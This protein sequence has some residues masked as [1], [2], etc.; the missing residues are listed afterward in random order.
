MLKFR[1]TGTVPYEMKTMGL[2]PGKIHTLGPQA[3][4]DNLPYLL[5]AKKAG[6]IDDMMGTVDPQQPK[7]VADQ[8]QAIIGIYSDVRPVWEKGCVMF[9]QNN[10][11][12]Y[13]GGRVYSW[14]LGLA[15][16]K[17]GIPASMVSNRVPGFVDDFAAY[18]D[19][20]NVVR[21]PH[22]DTWGQYPVPHDFAIGSPMSGVAAVPYGKRFGVPSILMVFDPPNFVRDLT[23][24]ENAAREGVWAKYKGSLMMADFVLALCPVAADY[25]REWLKGYPRDRVLDLVPGINSL[26]QRAAPEA[27]ERDTI[28]YLGRMVGFKQR[29]TIFKIASR[30]KPTPRVCIMG[31]VAGENNPTVFKDLA[32]DAGVKELVC[33]PSVDDMRKFT[34][35]KRSRFHVT[36]SLFEGFGMT[37]AES[38]A[39][40]TPSVAYPLPSFTAEYGDSID[41]ADAINDEESLCRVAEKLWSDDP[42]WED[43]S[44]QAV[45]AA[46]QFSFESFTQRVH[47]MFPA[48]KLATCAIVYREAEYLKQWLLT[49]MPWSNV[50]VL[51]EG[52]VKGFPT[53]PEDG[54]DE[55]LK[56]AD[57][58]PNVQV[59]RQKLWENKVEMQN[60]YLKAVGQHLDSCVVARPDID[61]FCDPRQMI[62]AGNRLRPHQYL[63][64]HRTHL[65][66]EGVVGKERPTLKQ[67]VAGL[68]RKPAIMVGGRWELWPPR[69][70]KFERGMRFRGS[71]DAVQAADGRRIAQEYGT[72]S[73]F[74]FGYIKSWGKITP[75]IA[76]YRWRGD[77]EE[78]S[79]EVWTKAWPE[80]PAGTGA[81]RRLDALPA[82]VNEVLEGR[83]Y[84]PERS[85]ADVSVHPGHWPNQPS[86]A[87][88]VAS[89]SA[90]R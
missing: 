56:W 40:G 34:E 76:Y 26:V 48:G 42:Y 16:A 25:A 66:P 45:R 3:V 51:V 33:L 78:S 65:W 50:V 87:S 17:T 31:G 46:Q 88:G 86:W 43:R 39:C 59:I 74:H 41:Y 44:S 81:V 36:A 20:V 79:E 2:L 35:L 71:P 52:P 64:V 57:G 8:T 63:G 72:V 54:T 53:L 70:F 28:T 24:Q 30:L 89:V 32:K 85:N 14:L 9:S 13:A 29:D 1:Y 62:M 49:Y 61:E 83:G 73:C 68:R 80:K 47:S 18:P 6:L 12:L 75:K 22:K 37:P 11:E 55:L 15:L 5:E 84:A 27:E 69:I 38:L 21:M 77:K 23:P 58:F 4:E 90:G 60:A 82:G 7:R 67:V 10:P 19:Q